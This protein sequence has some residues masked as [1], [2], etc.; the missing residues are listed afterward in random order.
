MM[1]PSIKSIVIFHIRPSDKKNLFYFFVVLNTL[2]KIKGSQF[3]S[4]GNNA[5]TN[6]EK[7][8]L[9]HTILCLVQ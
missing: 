6:P 4:L 1:E 2:S 7:N 5:E 3:K 9:K 8:K